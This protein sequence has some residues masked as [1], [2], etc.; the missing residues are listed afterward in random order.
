[1]STN[2]LQKLIKN[3]REI[4]SIAPSSPFL[5]DLMTKVIP[6]GAH[7]LELGPGTGN[8]TKAI[9][10]K[11]GSNPKLTM[12]EFEPELAELCRQQ[13]PQATVY[14]GRME[15][16]FEQDKNQFDVIISGIPFNALSTKN[17]L[18]A[19]QEIAKRVKPDGY[20]IMYQYLPLS[21][22]ELK[23]FFSDVSLDFT[24]LNLPPA[25]A[26]LARHPKPSP[27]NKS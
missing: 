14:A 10:Q 25:F 1:M 3:P 21:V 18:D 27:A 16:F 9:L 5:A 13:F 4:G 8:I 26:L 7:V 6:S 11:L 23:N 17:R 12:V 15:T 2:W 24:T 19:F 20:F 22:G